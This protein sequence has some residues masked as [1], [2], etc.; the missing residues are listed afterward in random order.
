MRHRT[1]PHIPVTPFLNEAAGGGASFGSSSLEP[2]L[3]ERGASPSVLLT[4]MR[5]FFFFF[6]LGL[7]LTLLSIPTAFFS[8]DRGAVLPRG[9]GPSRDAALFSFSFCRISPVAVLNMLSPR[10]LWKALR[11]SRGGHGTPFEQQH[12]L[13]TERRRPRDPLLFP[14]RPISL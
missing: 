7:L 11:L 3:L 4:R 2:L 6:L 5:V 12:V 13:M 8:V 10:E 14:L 9:T 1:S